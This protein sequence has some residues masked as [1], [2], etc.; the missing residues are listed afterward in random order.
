MNA[1]AASLHSTSMIA[2]NNNR[3]TG[4]INQLREAYHADIRNSWQFVLRYA[5]VKIISLM[6]VMVGCLCGVFG[7]N[8]QK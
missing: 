7:G 8:C 5:I 3:L 4:G 2:Y 6:M 1:P